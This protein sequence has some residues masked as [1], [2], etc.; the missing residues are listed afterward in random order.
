M[1]NKIK[2][3]LALLG[4]TKKTSVNIVINLNSLIGSTELKFYSVDSSLVERKLHEKLLD[5][6]R[7]FSAKILESFENAL[8]SAANETLKDSL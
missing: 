5:V 4:L 3:I 2:K 8:S 6:E 7:E 1:K